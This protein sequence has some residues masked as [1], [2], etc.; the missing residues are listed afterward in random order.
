M[1]RSP[2]FTD[3]VEGVADR[4]ECAKVKVRSSFKCSRNRKKKMV[5]GFTG[6]SKV[7]G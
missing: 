6:E 1:A 4:T 7:E 3:L 5:S 2:P